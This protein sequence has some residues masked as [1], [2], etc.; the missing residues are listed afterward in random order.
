MPS[1]LLLFEKISLLG[2]GMFESVV[3]DQ[4]LMWRC[5]PLISSLIEIATTNVLS[6]SNSIHFIDLKLSQLQ[7]PISMQGPRPISV[8]LSYISL[9]QAAI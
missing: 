9:Q 3:A 1:V 7:Y 5:Y 2:I 4:G 6:S 8:F